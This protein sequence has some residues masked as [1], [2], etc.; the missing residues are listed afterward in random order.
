MFQISSGKKVTLN[1]F[2]LPIPLLSASRNPERVNMD[3]AINILTICE[4]GAKVIKLGLSYSKTGGGLSEDIQTL[5]SEVGLLSEVL[6]SVTANLLGGKNG[7]MEHLEALV[8]ECRKQLDELCK[9]LE[10]SQGTTGSISNAIGR[11]L[12]W[13]LKE[14]ETKSWV[15]K[16]ERYKN[17]FM[18]ALKTEEM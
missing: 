6:N 15:N 7:S 16:I 4:I 2:Y 12:R 5:L 11:R 9:F 1:M 17:T 8:R 13:P 18:L 3:I 10:K 14:G